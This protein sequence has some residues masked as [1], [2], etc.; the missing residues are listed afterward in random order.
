MSDTAWAVLTSWNLRPEVILVLGTMLTTYLVGWIRLRRLNPSNGQQIKLASVW[1]LFV[2]VLGIV[3]LVLALV[4]PIEAL[5]GQFFFMH[6][7]QHLLMVMFAPPLLWIANPFPIAM[8]GL[9]TRWRIVI[10]RALFVKNSPVRRALTQIT[11]PGAGLCCYFIILWG[12]HDPRMYNWT[13]INERVHDTEHLS[14]YLSA[15]VTWW[16]ITGAAPRFRKRLGFP[17][18]IVLA[19]ISLVANMATGVVI[20]MSPN[21]IYTYYETVPFRL[22]NMSV[23]YDQTLGGAIMWVPG[24]MMY[25]LAIVILVAGLIDSQEKMRPARPKIAV[26]VSADAS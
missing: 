21:V 7:I 25:V 10:G 4:S 2:Y 11:K 18:R 9:P 1:R 26:P 5:S 3:C 17:V 8:W 24:S 19:L 14:F 15:M 22:W 23:L 20:A 16:S 13:L 6:M 12:W